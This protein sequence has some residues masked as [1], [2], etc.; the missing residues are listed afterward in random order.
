L[1]AK[2][3]SYGNSAG[4]FAFYFNVPNSP[5]QDLSGVSVAHAKVKIA[6]HHF[7]NEGPPTHYAL[8]L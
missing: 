1:V 7:E 2:F 3:R 6:G 8:G 4:S 5:L